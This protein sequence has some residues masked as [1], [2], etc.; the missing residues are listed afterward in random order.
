MLIKHDLH[1]E[2]L[3]LKKIIAIILLLE[4]LLNLRNLMRKRSFQFKLGLKYPISTREFI[5]AYKSTHTKTIF[6]VVIYYKYK[7]SHIS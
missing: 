1:L 4:I 5:Y 3:K 2:L 6:T 7:T